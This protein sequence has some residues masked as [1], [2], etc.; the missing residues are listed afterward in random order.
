MVCTVMATRG[1][2]S[3]LAGRSSNCSV[4]RSAE[5]GGYQWL[6]GEEW[7]AVYSWLYSSDPVL[8][9]RGVGRVSA[10]K[11]RGEVPMMVELTAD[12][13]GCRLRERERSG[14]VA[15]FQPLQLQYSMAITRLGNGYYQV[16]NSP[17]EAV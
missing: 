3:R 10:W 1:E 16:R 6:C 17:S 7:E 8:I 2:R 13:C 15:N 14:G 9:E 5:S 11:A 12:L 4:S